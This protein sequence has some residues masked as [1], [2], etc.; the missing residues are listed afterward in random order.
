MN[1]KL[2][3]LIALQT[4][5]NDA[6]AEL[7]TTNIAEA[8]QTQAAIAGIALPAPVVNVAAPAPVVVPAPV[9]NVSGG[10]SSVEDL[11]AEIANFPANN[12]AQQ[13][14]TIPAGSQGVKLLFNTN[15]TIAFSDDVEPET[16]QVGDRISGRRGQEIW[17]Y[18]HGN[19]VDRVITGTIPRRASVDVIAYYAPATHPNFDIT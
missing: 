10:G 16:G 2:A 6:L 15:T 18:P 17:V 11:R 1:E 12:S 4:A 13:T 19:L 14:F 7:R 3:E 5:T 8:D 9:V